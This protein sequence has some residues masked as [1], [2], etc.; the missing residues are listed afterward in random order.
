M[1]IAAIAGQKVT[2][3][4]WIGGITRA[5]GTAALLGSAITGACSSPQ[6]GSAPATKTHAPVTLQ[7]YENALFPWRQ[8]V[9][10]AITDPLLAANPWLTLDTSVPAG[11]I[12]EKFVAAS[13]AG[14]PPDTY[15]AN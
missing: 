14:S 3:R 2:R 5:I 7:I 15:N 6:P 11:D 4:Q 9:G 13:A 12:R 1:A 10:K 8:D